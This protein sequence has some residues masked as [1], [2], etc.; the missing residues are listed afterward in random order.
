MQHGEQKSEYTLLIYLNGGEDS[1]PPLSGGETIFHAT[2]KKVRLHT[3]KTL[4][5]TYLMNVP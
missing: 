2:T 3:L 1:L 4:V 5:G